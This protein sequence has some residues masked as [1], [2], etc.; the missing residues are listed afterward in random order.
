MSTREIEPIYTSDMRI[1]INDMTKGISQIRHA[2]W[3]LF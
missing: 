1:T 3:D 2:T